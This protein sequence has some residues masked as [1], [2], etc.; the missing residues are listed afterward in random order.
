M[1]DKIQV[2]ALLDA[3]GEL[4][5]EKQQS[6]CDMYF[7][8]DY[9]Y[10]E[11]AEIEGIS[12]AAVYDTIRRCRSELARYE[13]ILHMVEDMKKRQ[14]IIDQIEKLTDNADLLRLIHEL[15][16]TETQEVI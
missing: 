11:I 9:S 4:L 8:E 6:I 13:S 15:K 12:R 10:Q 14:S 3:Y 5:T 16:N 2:N 7:R 1:T